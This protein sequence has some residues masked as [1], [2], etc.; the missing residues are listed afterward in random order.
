MQFNHRVEK[1]RSAQCHEAAPKGAPRGYRQV[2]LGQVGR[3]WAKPIHLPMA[4]RATDK[5]RETVNRRIPGQCQIGALA[6]EPAQRHER[7]DQEQGEWQP[8]IPARAIK[9]D[10]EA[11]QID[12]Q[13]HDPKEGHNGYVL[14]QLVRGSDQENRA[15]RRQQYPQKSDQDRWGR[16]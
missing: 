16:G 10:D 1:Q 11:Q 2:K 7:S 5:Q 6:Q 12:R 9:R 14:A 13:R 15:A 4:D 3:R 8:G